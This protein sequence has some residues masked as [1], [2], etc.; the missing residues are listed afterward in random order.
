MVAVADEALLNITTTLRET[1]LW[2]NTLVVF[3]SDNGGPIY[4]E[5]W[6]ETGGSSLFLL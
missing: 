4:D 3:M 1:G 2:N 5:N 6:K